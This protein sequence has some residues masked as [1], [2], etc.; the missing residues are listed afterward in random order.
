VRPSGLRGM[1]PAYTE[2]DNSRQS[3]PLGRKVSRAPKGGDAGRGTA[4]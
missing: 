3:S 1:T 4:V 2:D